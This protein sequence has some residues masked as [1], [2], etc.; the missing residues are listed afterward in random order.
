MS[1]LFADLPDE[2]PRI[3]GV[4]ESYGAGERVRALCT[5]WQSHPPANLSW[6][7]NAEPAREDYL[8]RYELRKEYDLTFIS[9]LG[10][11]FVAQPHHFRSDSGGNSDRAMVLRCSS[12]LLSVYW[13]SS[14]V[15]IKQKMSYYNGQISPPMTKH[16][17]EGSSSNEGR[18][19]NPIRH[20]RRRKGQVASLSTV[21]FLTIFRQ[22]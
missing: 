11:E 18:G 13:Q 20:Q 12:S 7:I 4:Q 17:D 10:V 6:F 21:F 3:T 5:S 2:K 14:V 1:F 9:V 16:T 8:R 19:A 15:R 22:F